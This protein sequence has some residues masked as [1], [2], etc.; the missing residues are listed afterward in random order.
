MSSSTE[1]LI[2]ARKLQKVPEY[3]QA[4]EI[5]EKIL[6]QKEA[7][8]EDIL[9]AK[10]GLAF[11]IL[12][13]LEIEKDKSRDKIAFQY[14]LAVAAQKKHPVALFNLGYCYEYARGT[15]E[16]P[17]LNKALPFYQESAE[18]GNSSA[19]YF[20]GIFYDEGIGVEKNQT[21]ALAYY[22]LSA[23]KEN[24]YAKVSL[25][26]CYQKGLC[27]LRKNTKKAI[28]LYD[29]ASVQGDYL[30]QYRMGNYYEKKDQKENY[31]RYYTLS[32]RQQFWEAE[33]KLAL[34]YEKGYGCDINLEEAR[35]FYE[36]AL[37]HMFDINS[38]TSCAEFMNMKN[39]IKESKK[40][41]ETASSSSKDMNQRLCA[42]VHLGMK[43]KFGTKNFL[44]DVKKALC[45]FR[46][47]ALL[48]NAQGL[49]QL[50]KCYEKGVGVERDMKEAIRL[51]KKA[52]EKHES[53]A[54]NVLGIYYSGK[55]GGPQ[56]WEKASEFYTL[57]IAANPKGTAAIFNLA[58]LKGKQEKFPE[59]QQLF[60]TAAK[61]GY[62]DAQFGVGEC[63]YTGKGVTQ[64]IQEAVFWYKRAAVQGYALARERLE[65]C[66]S[67][68]EGVRKDTN[69]ARFYSK[70]KRKREI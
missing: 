58:N 22:I 43:Y 9:E 57:A 13:K 45:F 30:A 27:G 39:Q 17:N 32:A 24:E 66:Y 25:G 11:L 65:T 21:K 14:S 8:Q 51:Y 42:F 26:D 5:Y 6:E 63:Y 69:E 50:G 48:E 41:F 68:G 40:L 53:N 36:L 7:K 35:R 56:D 55:R 54:L 2:E 3:K 1:L 28:E 23:E 15:D 10:V 4:S 59:M 64:N 60:L 38:S 52:G 44:K 49:F 47:T 46:Y 37:K 19:L 70:K 31:L 62:V 18:L 61:M 12:T 16:N 29:Q 34:I 20:L 67:K 33:Y